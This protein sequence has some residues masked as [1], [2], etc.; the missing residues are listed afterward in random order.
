MSSTS[1][2]KSY[3]EQLT[4]FRTY[5]EP[6]DM[7]PAFEFDMTHRKSATYM[8][9]APLVSSFTGNLSYDWDLE[10]AHVDLDVNYIYPFKQIMNDIDKWQWYH[11][12]RAFTLGVP[13]LQVRE[14]AH[15]IDRVSKALPYIDKYR[16]PLR[17]QLELYTMM[18][19]KTLAYMTYS[20][21]WIT[22]YIHEHEYSSLGEGHKWY[23]AF[24]VESE[25]WRHILDNLRNM[26][27]YLLSHPGTYLNIP[28]KLGVRARSPEIEKLSNHYSLDF[29]RSRIITFHPQLSTTTAFIP[30]KAAWYKEV[31]DEAYRILHA[32]VEVYY[33]YVLAGNI[34]TKFRDQ[35]QKQPTFQA[36]DAR[37]GRQ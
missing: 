13:R 31:L 16:I 17:T 4:L 18:I 23:E 34:Y 29:D 32:D 3:V 8:P 36:A 33:P 24:S 37:R 25:F 28:Y 1:E 12:S 21:E 9:P 19:E 22:S 30:Q 11:R 35:F 26:Y 6:I 15:R 14:I 2:L 10:V 20:P 5:N 7:R 27:E